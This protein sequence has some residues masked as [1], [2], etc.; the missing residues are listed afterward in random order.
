[1]EE[2][3]L[4]GSESPVCVGP[5]AYLDH[6]FCLVLNVDTCKEII[7]IQA[8]LDGNIYMDEHRSQNFDGME[9][10]RDSDQVQDCQNCLK[11]HDTKIV[12]NYAKLC[13]SLY[14]ECPYFKVDL[15]DFQCQEFGVD[16]NDITDCG[17]CAE[18]YGCGWCSSSNICI[19]EDMQK[20]KPLC[21]IC[22]KKHY[23]SSQDQC[24][25]SNADPGGSQAQQ[26]EKLIG[27]L[28]IIIVV[29][30]LVGFLIFWYIR[31]KRQREEVERQNQQINSDG[32]NFNLL[33][34]DD[35]INNTGPSDD[36]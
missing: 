29:F 23:I 7:H 16:C 35:V 13:P 9:Y 20:E 2:I 1:M 15:K 21:E 34:E 17:K 11:F 10:C 8:T 4:F 6:Q 27:N 30:S 25:D 24:T 18:T 22:S 12:P 3:S 5:E 33:V 26:T 31:R 36:L 14:L 32:L 28:V 19:T